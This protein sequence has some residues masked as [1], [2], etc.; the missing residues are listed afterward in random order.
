MA[1]VRL[2]ARS[3][4]GPTTFRGSRIFGCRLGGFHA[5]AP[6][7]LI[8]NDD[9]CAGRG[10]GYRAVSGGLFTV[11]GRSVS[12][13]AVAAHA[14]SVAVAVGTGDRGADRGLPGQSADHW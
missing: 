1:V 9:R 5:L 10:D 14:P 8:P 6:V 3:R 7:P 13:S 11:G 4:R 12:A 2:L